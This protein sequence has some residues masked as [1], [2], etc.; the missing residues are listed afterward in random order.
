MTV[1]ENEDLEEAVAMDASP[2]S[3]QSENAFTAPKKAIG[4]AISL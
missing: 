3:G 4:Q 2:M 1:H